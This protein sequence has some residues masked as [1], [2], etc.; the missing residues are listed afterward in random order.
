MARKVANGSSE[1]KQKY[2]ASKNRRPAAYLIENIWLILSGGRGGGRRRLR[3][4]LQ[5][6]TKDQNVFSSFDVTQFFPNEP[7][8]IEGFFEQID[9]F[10]QFL[11]VVEELLVLAT[12]PVAKRIEVLKFQETLVSEHGEQPEEPENDQSEQEKESDLRFGALCH[13]EAFH[14]NRKWGLS[15][16]IS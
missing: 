5:I 16:L 15:H 1:V 12:D 7:F 6:F 8:R 9:L 4:G 13:D 2:P 11:I 14:H 3:L 10:D